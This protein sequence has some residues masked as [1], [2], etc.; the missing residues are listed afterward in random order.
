MAVRRRRSG[1]RGPV[2]TDRLRGSGRPRSLQ[3]A[4]AKMTEGLRGCEDH[5]RQGITEAELLTRDDGRGGIP[6]MPGSRAP[7]LGS[8]SFQGSR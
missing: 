1:S 4:P 3:E 2:A 6:V 8:R 7:M 5:R